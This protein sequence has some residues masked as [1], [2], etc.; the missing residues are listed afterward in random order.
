[1]AE[2]R[3]YYKSKDNKCYFS[4]KSPLNEEELKKYTEITVEQWNEYQAEIA[5]KPLTEAEK[6]KQEKLAEIA[7]LKGELARTD[8]CV[9]KIA[10]GVATPEEYAEV[11][12][13]RATWRARINEL[14]EEIKW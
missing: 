7:Q 11:L 14:E 10:E 5:P 1:M 3:Y 6:A 12:T 4:F 13:Q 9:I 2:K 8:Y